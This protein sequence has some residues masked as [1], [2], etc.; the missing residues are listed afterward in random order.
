MVTVE[1]N[2]AEKAAISS[3]RDRLAQ[4]QDMKRKAH[5]STA[6]EQADGVDGRPDKSEAADREALN[7]MQQNSMI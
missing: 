3:L 2:Q 6:H 4:A 1:D 7:Y 5:A